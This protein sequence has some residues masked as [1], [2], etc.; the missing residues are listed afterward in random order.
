M[1]I[2]YQTKN[3]AM[4]SPRTSAVATDRVPAREKARRGS[5][6]PFPVRSTLREARC[7]HYSMTV[8][9][10]PPRAKSTFKRGA[11]LTHPP[12]AIFFFN[13]TLFFRYNDAHP[14]GRDT[15]I[16]DMHPITIRTVG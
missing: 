5:S 14:M 16:P 13:C 15:I 6:V 9:R 4:S 11:G 12:R 1:V 8:L 3:Q 2:S 7:L 10:L